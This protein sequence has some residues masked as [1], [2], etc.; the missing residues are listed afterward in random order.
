MKV[1]RVVN[2]E[3]SGIWDGQE[4]DMVTWFP[5]EQ[6]IPTFDPATQRLDGPTFTV[7]PDKVNEVYSVVDM[8]DEEL[9]A[10][11]RDA[12]I[13][14]IGAANLLK[15]VIDL[16]NGD[17]TAL[18]ANQATISAAQ[19]AVSAGLGKGSQIK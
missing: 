9:S 6:L 8:S 2:G 18:A 10:I 4:V 19:G 7:G 16:V 13:N 14:Q 3:F 1:A 15:M 17:A 12:L 5:V 11:Q